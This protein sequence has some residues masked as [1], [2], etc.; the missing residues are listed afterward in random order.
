MVY[1]L[2]KLDCNVAP[3]A[4]RKCTKERALPAGSMSRAR[5]AQ[6]AVLPT[7][8]G[9][10]PSVVKSW[11]LEETQRSCAEKLPPTDSTTVDWVMEKFDV[12]FRKPTGGSVVSVPSGSRLLVDSLLL[13]LVQV[14]AM[15]SNSSRTW[16]GFVH[17]VFM[18]G[19]V[20]PTTKTARAHSLGRAQ[21][22][23]APQ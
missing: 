3:L 7:E 18:C 22:T 1:T 21:A 13:K 10:L 2:P 8:M 12:V 16:V 4:S 23:S 17:T 6:W 19:A 15:R 9:R 11:L 20:Q 14:R 5:Q